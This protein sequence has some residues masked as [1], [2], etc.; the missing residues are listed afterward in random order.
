MMRL[1]A[2]LISLG[3]ACMISLEL[4]QGPFLSNWVWAMPSFFLGVSFVQFMKHLNELE[5]S[6]T[7]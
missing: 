1:L 7:K 5:W 3:F 2:S 6:E 4:W